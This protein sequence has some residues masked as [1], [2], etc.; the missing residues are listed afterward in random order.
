M[1]KKLRIAVL[2]AGGIFAA[3]AP[4]FNRLP[5]LCEVVAVA[6]PNAERYGVVRD[7]LKKD[8]PF[9][10]D[11]K[12]LLALPNLEEIV[13]AVVILTPHDMHMDGAVKAA[14]RGLHVLVEKVMAR[15]VYEC[16]EMINACDKAGVVLAVAHDR[17]YAGDWVAM[18]QIIDSGKLGE[19]LFIK[20]EH[21]QDVAAPEGSWIRTVDGMGGGAIMSCLCH[22]IDALRWYFGEVDKISCI[23]KILPERMEGECFG[24]IN[25]TMK[26]GALALLNINWYTQCHSW[27]GPVG[28]DLWYE[29]TH[30]TGTHGEAYTM[31][32]KG[33]FFKPNSKH[34]P[35]EAVGEYA[36]KAKKSAGFVKVE[37]EQT[38]TGHQKCI[39]EFVKA[40][41]G[42][43]AQV[44]TLGTDTIKT[45][46]IA[47]A[48]YLAEV[49]N[50][51][52]TL[53]IKQPV[54]WDQ[55]TYLK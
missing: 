21:N 26:S 24:S 47:E 37:A 50:T 14:N 52:V 11:Y 38:I 12:D 54:P 4:G 16:Q 28:D 19:I 42:M 44:L 39:E 7:L 2:G 17:R 20:M 1:S 5:D 30:V 31:H 33:T 27:Q 46:E 34:A 9:Y 51:V 55:R 40:A 3:H 25:A 29:F 35:D 32:K 53:P 45:V 48:A 43:P 41:L 22:Q 23:H 10:K 13:D 8:V 36:G 6:E 49:S 18:K 15:N